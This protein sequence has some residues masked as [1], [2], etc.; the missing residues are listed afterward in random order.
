M[1]DR[2]KATEGA[3][4]AAAAWHRAESLD[5]LAGLVPRT[6][7]ELIPCDAAGWYELDSARRLVRSRSEPRL[8]LSERTLARL[9]RGHPALRHARATGDRRART[10]SDCLSAREFRR[11]R[12]YRD[13]YRRI[14][15]ADQLAAA[16]E[17]EGGRRLAILLD[18]PSRSF[19]TRDRRLLDLVS[20]HIAASYR[21]LERIAALEAALRHVGKFV[22][23]VDDEC[24]LVDVTPALADLLSDWFGSVPDRLAPGEYERAEGTLL[25]DEVANAP[26]RLLVLDARRVF[27]PPRAE[28]LGLTRRE[29][30]VARL[31]AQGLSNQAIG[32]RLAVSRRTVHKHLQNVYA[33]LGV[34]TRAA[35]AE[36]LLDGT[37]T[38]SSS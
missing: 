17:L 16:I 13:V 26:A 34:R 28:A 7:R 5:E 29:A 10:I 36:L 8:D 30:E 4:A 9:I 23:C 32:E 31:A 37:E 3:L 14:G 15:V 19:S 2:R 12:L 22:A 33:K 27:S 6:L 25:V 24:G 18:R 35:A 38:E 11:T 1:A 21:R 20:V